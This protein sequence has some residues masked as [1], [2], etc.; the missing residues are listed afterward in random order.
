MKIKFILTGMFLYL[1]C[2]TLG[3]IAA[4]IPT[5]GGD[6]NT[7]GTKLNTFL[8]V[9]HETSGAYGGKVRS[10]DTIYIPS[11][12]TVQTTVQNQLRKNIYLSDFTSSS[13]NTAITAIGSSSAR[14]IIDTSATCSGSTVIPA[15]IVS[16]VSKTGSV[17]VTGTLTINGRFEADRYYIFTGSGSVSFGE[18][19]VEYVYPEWWYS[20]TGA[21]TTALTN[22]IASITHNETVSLR[23]DVYEI[24]AEISIVPLRCNIQG[25]R[26]SQETDVANRGTVLKFTGSGNI[27]CAVLSIVGGYNNSIDNI[28]IDCND[29][30][31][32]GL[33]L[34]ADNNESVQGLLHF[35]S[36]NLQISNA[37]NYGLYLGDR[38]S[39]VNGSVTGTADAFVDYP[40]F[41]NYVSYDNKVGLRINSQ[42]TSN[43]TFYGGEYYSPHII[44]NK[45]IYHIYCDDVYNLPLFGVQFT[46]LNLDTGVRCIHIEKGAVQIYGGY[47]EVT[48]FLKVV[49]A[50]APQL[51]TVVSNVTTTANASDDIY[52]IDYNGSGRGIVLSGV[53]ITNGKVICR[54][55]SLSMQNCDFKYVV[56]DG[57]TTDDSNIVPDPT[58]NV[59]PSTSTTPW[60]VS[61]ATASSE[62]TIKKVGNNSIKVIGD[63]VSVTGTLYYDIYT[64]AGDKY[65][66]LRGQS[67]TFGALVYNV[68][69][70]DKTQYI[71]IE[72]IPG[73]SLVKQAIPKDNSWHYVGLNTTLSDTTTMVRIHITTNLSAVDAVPDYLYVNA[74]SFRA[75]R[76]D[77]KLLINNRELR[78]QVTWDAASIAANAVESKD[79]TVNN[80]ELGDFVVSSAGLDLQGLNLSGNVK[81]TGTVTVTL[82]NNT[83]APVDL[84][85]SVY[86]IKVISQ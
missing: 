72:Q 24:D 42:N 77:E 22:A 14:L 57:F 4:D 83:G 15:N 8:G 2:C 64:D 39:S 25:V 85:S 68:S 49:N 46:A 54:S 10:T 55:G 35:T 44:G 12:G 3:V 51:M 78:G 43:P 45:C 58:F 30:A 53:S 11:P 20:G 23:S 38:L 5:V 62:A 48:P 79:V 9:A 70:N 33:R 82:S 32:Y 81:S 36:T 56:N 47:N 86:R 21:Y 63:G 1:I 59:I 73:G 52:D 50:G 66:F 69:T 29:L 31:G 71:M 65:S 26:G 67:V 74:A 41:Y 13:L 60:L 18:G 16:F 75:G 7:W 17:N 19:V 28:N 76:N 40:V 37:L 34:Q 80:A 27:H 61:G 84:A 6:K